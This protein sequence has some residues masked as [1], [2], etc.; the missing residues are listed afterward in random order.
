[1]KKIPKTIHYLQKEERVIQ[2]VLL[3]KIFSTNITF[4]SCIPT[5]GKWIPT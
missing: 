5:S 4:P 3:M 1:M 2:P